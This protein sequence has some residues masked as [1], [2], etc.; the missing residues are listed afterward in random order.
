MMVE[1]FFLCL[2]SNYRL[3]ETTV[4]YITKYDNGVFTIK[5]NNSWL[6]KAD[7]KDT[8]YS[9]VKKVVDTRTQ[10]K[11]ASSTY[12]SVNDFELVPSSI[13]HELQEKAVRELGTK[14]IESHMRFPEFASS[15]FKPAREAAALLREKEP[16]Y[17]REIER[18]TR[19]R[20]ELEQKEAKKAADDSDSEYSE[21]ENEDER[22]VEEV[23]SSSKETRVQPAQAKKNVQESARADPRRTKSLST[24]DWLTGRFCPDLQEMYRQRNCEC[25]YVR[26]GALL[27][28]LTS[29]DAI[30]REE[31]QS[32]KPMK[33]EK[34][35]FS[36]VQDTLPS[37]YSTA[38]V[39]SLEEQWD[40]NHRMCKW[41]LILLVTEPIE[42]YKDATS[43]LVA[44]LKKT[45]YIVKGNKYMERGMSFGVLRF[46]CLAFKLQTLRSRGIFCLRLAMANRS[47][48]SR[49][50]S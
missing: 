11:Y 14:V 41:V 24:G 30:V 20:M 25:M 21:D 3:G 27:D 38:E 28:G 1:C 37:T 9:F 40:Q 8:M 39:K 13:S 7:G 15:W 43:P 49:R 10:T 29:F 19:R 32:S 33:K 12:K 22:E 47:R 5:C 36:I 23:G 48:E 31:K 16:D 17:V 35:P 45:E 6:C 2:K 34:I 44:V 46:L 42:N 26:E 4:Q 18:G 50:N